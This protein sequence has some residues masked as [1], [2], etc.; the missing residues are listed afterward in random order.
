MGTL[1]T[2]VLGVVGGLL[3][4]EIYDRLSNTSAWL[5]RFHSSRLPADLQDRLQEEWLAVLDET[6]GN[7]SKFIFAV[8]L[9]RARLRITSETSTRPRWQRTPRRVWYLFWKFAPHG[10][11]LLTRSAAFWLSLARILIFSM[12]LASMIAWVYAA[13]I[14]GEGFFGLIVAGFVGVI[15]FLTVWVISVSL[16]TWDQAW[17]EHAKLILKWHPSGRGRENFSVALRMALLMTSLWITAPYL[18][19]V[20][21]HEDIQ[22]YVAAEATGALDAGRTTLADNYDSLIVAKEMEVT[23]KRGEYEREVSGKGASGLKGLGPIAEALRQDVLELQSERDGLIRQRQDA[24]ATFD[25]L[26]SSWELNRKRLAD[27]YNV[28][29]LPSGILQNQ[30]AVEFLRTL[31]IAI[32]NGQ[33]PPSL[34]L[35]S[36]AYWF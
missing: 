28:I 5:V 4:A 35:Y 29:I 18:G 11:R 16:I 15:V 2:I 19:Q 6:T 33:S 26:A 21:F 24:L 3:A 12:A 7:L 34:H 10:E 9:R 17:R 30:K 13:F 23:E 25:Q 31:P 32:P 8:D 1:V 22:R 20:A 36:S 14:L 27:E